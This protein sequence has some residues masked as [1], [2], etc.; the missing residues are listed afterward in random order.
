MSKQC[1]Y[2][3]KPHDSMLKKKESAGYEVNCG[4]KI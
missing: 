4:Y 2:R 3:Y 1:G